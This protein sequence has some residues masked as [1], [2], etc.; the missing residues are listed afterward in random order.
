MKGS[1]VL[2][3]ELEND[4]TIKVGKLGDIF[5]KKGFYVYVGGALNG[6]EKR[7]ERHKRSDK[8]FHWHIDYFLKHGKIQ[9]VFYKESIKKEECEISKKFEN[10]ESIYGFGCSDCKCRSH[11]FYGSKKDIL[12]IISEIGMQNT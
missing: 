6:L 12:Q 7:I 11:L 3:I 8:K 2:L 10:F 5:F 9:N 1:Y 4:L